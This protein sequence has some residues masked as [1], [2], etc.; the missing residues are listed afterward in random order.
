[1]HQV[2][3]RELSAEETYKLLTGVVVPRPIAW[4]TTQSA[5]GVVNLAPFSCYTVVSTQP[6]L[7]GINMG[8][9]AGERKDTARNALAR[10]EFV[11]NIGNEDMVEAIHHSAIE[12][13]PEVSEVETLGLRLAPSVA[14]ATPRLADVPISLE[15]RLHQVIP[16]GDTG[17]EFVVGEVLHLHADP[18][19]MNGPRIDSQRLRPVCR[20]GGPLYGTLGKLITQPPIAQTPKS[21]LP[22]P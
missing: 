18:A 21:V 1:M 3:L 11:V 14:I 17:A 20:L 6:P 8:R 5:A 4:I 10:G 9:K 16:F 15:C 7:L 2:N 12:Y 13:P 22:K 19:V